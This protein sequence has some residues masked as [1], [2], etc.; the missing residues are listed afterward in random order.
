[1][2]ADNFVI[3]IESVEKR[4][5]KLT[6]SKSNLE[7]KGLTA[8]MRMTKVVFNGVNMDTLIGSGVWTCWCMDLWTC[9]QAWEIIQFIAQDASIGCTKNVKGIRSRLVENKDLGF[10]RCPGLA[11]SIEGCPFDSITLGEHTREVADIF[12]YLGDTVSAR[13]GGTN[14]QTWYKPDRNLV[15][16]ARATGLPSES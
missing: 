7:N 3:L 13:G 1:M 15:Q 2:H 16:I 4:Y 11:R 6:A 8:N 5:Q 10:D 12:C 14:V 9:D